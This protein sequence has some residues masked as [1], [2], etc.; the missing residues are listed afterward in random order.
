[1]F[2]TSIALVIGF[3]M[4]CFGK[5]ASTV[6]FGFLAACTMAVAWMSDL[7]ITP[8][9][10]HATPLITAWDLL[11][12][13]IGERGGRAQPALPRPQGVRGQAGGAARHRHQAR[14]RRPA[15]APGR[16][17][18][19]DAGPALGRGEDRGERRRVE[20][21][22][23]RSARSSPA[24]W[25]A[26][27]PSSPARAAPRRWSPPRTAR[28]C[29]STR[30]GCAGWRSASPRSPPRSTPTWPSSWAPRSSARRCRSSSRR[31]GRTGGG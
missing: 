12:L 19:L 25:S 8:A 16:R 31:L 4:L 3:A 10:L 2:T 22:P 21:A 30:P 13:K 14:G 17:G 29:A 6:Q 18:R 23:A 24:T 9:L 28:P 7:V 1:M 15:A 11:R 26:R 20:R 27:W 5:F